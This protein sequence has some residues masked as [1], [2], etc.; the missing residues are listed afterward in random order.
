MRTIIIR[1]LALALCVFA[2]P[3]LVLAQWVDYPTA[4]TPRTADGKPNLSAPAPKTREGK[5]SIAGIWTRVA[6]KLPPRP[7][8][9][10][11]DLTDWLMPG[12]EIQM[13]PW[14]QTLFHERAE[15]N[16]GAGRPSERCLPHG[17]PDGMLPGVIFKLIET[18]GV[19]LLL[20]EEFNHFRQIFTDGRSFPKDQPPAWL[21]YSIGKWEG[22]NFLVQSQGFNDQTWLDDSGHPH[23]EAMRTTETFHRIDFGH[24]DLTVTINDPKAYLEPWS[25]SIPLLLLPDTEL[26][27][28]V[29]DNERDSRHLDVK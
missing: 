18:P 14:A 21:G 8:G 2:A 17:I 22:N 27:E 11:N 16:L 29:C 19:T 3:T 23:T 1:P 24:M 28:D 5:A 26:L 7:A 10:P 25:V 4:G 12:S 6:P 20:Y 9:A 13:Q 15:K